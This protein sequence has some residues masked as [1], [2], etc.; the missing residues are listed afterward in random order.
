MTP[1]LI[2]I[3]ASVEQLVPRE[4]A[5]IEVLGEADP[6]MLTLSQ[7]ADRAGGHVSGYG[8]AVAAV[9]ARGFVAR[10]DVVPAYSGER[11]A[12]V[13]RLLPRGQAAYL[14]LQHDRAHRARRWQPSRRIGAAA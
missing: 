9:H 5:M 4:R 10:V 7:I 6:G 3:L 14:E 1:E 13:Y 11:P 8:S 12:P 2:A